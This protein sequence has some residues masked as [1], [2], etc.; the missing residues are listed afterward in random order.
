MADS[1]VL[2]L[3]IEVKKNGLTAV[4]L[5]SAET[6]LSND[7][8]KKV[9]QKGAVWLTHGSSTER[10]R[11]V[12][13]QLHEGNT[14]HLY[15]NPDVIDQSPPTAELIHDGGDYTVWNK[16]AGMLSQGSRWGDHTTI[17]RWAEKHLSPQRPAFIV[18]R[19]DRAA[20]GLILLAHTKKSAAALSA[21]FQKRAVK[22]TY[23]AT[24]HGLFSPEQQPLTIETPIDGK[25]A[26]SHLTLVS[27]DIEQDRSTIKISIETGRKHQIRRHLSEIGHPIAGDRLYGRSSDQED[28]MLCS[29]KLS[30]ISP[31]DREEKSFTISTN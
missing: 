14:V 27:Q 20:H 2:E 23:Q 10:I 31:A 16:P 25:P 6:A 12:K 17:Y 19:L 28:L 4:E 3:H 1:S 18:H 5:L 29:C 21:L 8:I 24:V 15:Y 9:M 22:K 11:R 13:R 30:F 7:L 26:V